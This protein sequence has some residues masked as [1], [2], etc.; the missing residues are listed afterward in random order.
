MRNVARCIA[1]WT[2]LPSP[3][4]GVAVTL[5][6]EIDP[7]GVTFTETFTWPLADDLSPHPITRAF[8][9]ETPSEIIATREGFATL[10]AAVDHGEPVA[11][12]DLFVRTGGERR[13]SDF[14]LWE[15]AYAE[16]YFTDTAWPDFGAVDGLEPPLRNFWQHAP[17]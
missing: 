15:S 12:V 1:D 9:F 5:T 16:L 2:Q 3:G 14:L 6:L 7:S 10:L 13:L 4:S 11:P 8:T 17:S